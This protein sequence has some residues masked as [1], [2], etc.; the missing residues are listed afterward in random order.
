MTRYDK[1][2]WTEITKLAN[3]APFDLIELNLSCPHGM[4]ELG[5][6]RACGENP[7]MVKNI[8][9]WVSE[10]SRVP[11]IIKVT[12]NYSYADEIAKAAYDGGAWGVCMTNTYPALMDPKPDGDPWPAVGEKKHVAFGGATGSFLRPIALRKCTETALT[13]P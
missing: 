1:D 7:E 2:D 5:M 6:G 9:K 10:V 3:T 13:V 12:P 11:V 4:T 8:A